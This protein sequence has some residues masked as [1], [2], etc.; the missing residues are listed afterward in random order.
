MDHFYSPTPLFRAPAFFFVLF[1]AC[2][3]RATAI[4]PFE[5]IVR[6]YS[7]IWVSLKIFVPAAGASKNKSWNN[8]TPTKACLTFALSIVA[9]PTS[10]A[11]ME[12]VPTFCCAVYVLKVPMFCRNVNWP[13]DANTVENIVARIRI[14]FTLIPDASAI[15]ISL[16]TLLKSCPSFVFVMN[17]HN[18]LTS[19]IKPNVATGTM[20][21][22]MMLDNVGTVK[23]SLRR[24]ACTD[25]SVLTCPPKKQSTQKEKKIVK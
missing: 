18:A 19:R 4:T 15:W 10:N 14:L 2:S 16:P 5:M 21:F 6:K 3:T 17:W 22:W 20:H 1:I 7:P 13:Q 9:P 25:A 23:R 24:I 12:K 8:T 11:A